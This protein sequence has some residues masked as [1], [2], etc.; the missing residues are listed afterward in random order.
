M[1]D[2]LSEEMYLKKVERLARGAMELCVPA[3]A[4]NE[5]EKA[6]S[7]AKDQ[8]LRELLSLVV[9]ELDDAQATAK[10]AHKHVEMLLALRGRPFDHRDLYERD[11][12]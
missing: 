9:A 12:D 1:S 4:L 2:A 10:K 5:E 7:L 6:E 8:D 11:T 3:E